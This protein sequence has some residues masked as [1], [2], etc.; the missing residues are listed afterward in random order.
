MKHLTF[1]FTE[2]FGAKSMCV[3]LVF[4]ASVTEGYGFSCYQKQCVWV[5]FNCIDDKHIVVQ[6]PLHCCFTVTESCDS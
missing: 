4:S 6:L 2:I 3:K 1:I 5:T